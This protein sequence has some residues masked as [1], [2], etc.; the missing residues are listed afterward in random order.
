VAI[1]S[2][3]IPSFTDGTVVHQADL[4]ALATNLT[5]LYTYNQGAFNSQRPACMA[6][7]T[8]T[9]AI[10]NNVPTLVNFN[11]APVNVGSMWVGSQ[12]AQ[13]T[14]QVAGIYYLFG[15]V[16]YSTLAGATLGIV[17]RG[18]IMI[19]GTTPATNSVCNTDVP[20]MTAGN[21]P[22]SAAW[23]VANLAVGAVVYLDTLHNAGAGVS[24]TLLYG[25]SFLSAF[26]VAAPA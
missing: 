11:S 8:V 21:G 15:Q 22:T 19:N 13:I 12:P 1:P 2:P 26:F 25:G 6:V 24:T 9:Q 4:N 18:N 3:V 10:T 16:R 7:Q 5:N 20:F 17:S 23:F 14:I